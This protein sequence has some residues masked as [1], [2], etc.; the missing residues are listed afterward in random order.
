MIV[1]GETLLNDVTVSGDLTAGLIRFDTLENSIDILGPSWLDPITGEPNTILCES[2]PLFLQK[3]LAGNIDLLDGTVT[4]SPDGLV[5][6]Q[7]EIRAE[8]YSVASKTTDDASAG[9]SVIL[10]GETVI[11]VTTTALNDNSLIFVTPDTPVLL[12]TRKIGPTEFEI[13]ID[14]KEHN[15]IIVSW[16]IVDS[17]DRLTFDGT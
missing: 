5:D 15:D 8:K 7:G 9:K 12:G 1:L 13:T 6:V 14:K 16:W 2:Q 11:T 4:I 3:N 10:A 17:V